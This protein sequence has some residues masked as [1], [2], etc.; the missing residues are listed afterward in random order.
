[1]TPSATARW[2]WSFRDRG[3]VPLRLE[4]QF[5]EGSNLPPSDPLLLFHTPVFGKPVDVAAMSRAVPGHWT[6]DKR[7]ASEAAAVICHMPDFREVGDA[8]KYPGQLWVAWSQERR[9][10]YPVMADP[11]F[12][13]H[14]DIRMTYESNAD[15][16]M[17]SARSHVVEECA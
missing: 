13:R 5:D 10:N 15:V 2:G 17:P 1:M 8:R 4:T 6:V 11:P 12:T 7:R 16:W 9:Q 3:D 14:F